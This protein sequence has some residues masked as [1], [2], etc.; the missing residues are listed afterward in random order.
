MTPDE[1]DDVVSR[2]SR[3]MCE[4]TW[5]HG[6][7]KYAADV[8]QQYVDAGATW[9]SVID[10]LPPVLEPEDAQGALSRSIEVCRHL[11]EPT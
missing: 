4:K 1:I 5:I 6:T 7:P 8:L 3:P 2:V 11:K 10:L 9:V